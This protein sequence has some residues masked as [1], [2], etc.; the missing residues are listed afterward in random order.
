MRRSDISSGYKTPPTVIPA[1]GKRGD[2]LQTASNKDCC[3]VFQEDKRRSNVIDDAH[4]LEEKTALLSTKAFTASGS[5][6]VR[7]WEPSVD[8]VCESRRQPERSN[9]IPAWCSP[10]LSAKLSG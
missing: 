5:R 8:D 7:A 9:I 6:N 4:D 10:D 2:D 1:F 3:D